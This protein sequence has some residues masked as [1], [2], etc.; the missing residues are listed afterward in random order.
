[1]LRAA[2]VFRATQP[3]RLAAS[4]RVAFHSSRTYLNEKVAAQSARVLENS[5]PVK[6]SN[7]FKRLLVSSLLFSTIAYGA[8]IFYSIKNDSFYEVFVEYIPFAERIIHFIED[9]R[10]KGKFSNWES[11]RNAIT[12]SHVIP[13][14]LDGTIQV[15]RAGVD[16]KAIDPSKISVKKSVAP[17]PVVPKEPE[18]T[19]AP[20]PIEMAINLPIVHLPLGADPEVLKYAESL[21]LLIQSINNHKSSAEAVERVSA[22]IL[23]LMSTAT[24]SQE[25]LKEKLEAEFKKKLE[26]VKSRHEREIQSQKDNYEFELQREQRALIENYNKRLAVELELTKNTTAAYVENQIRAIISESQRQFAGVVTEKVQDQRNARLAMIKKFSETVKELEQLTIQSNEIIAQAQK[27]AKLY[28]AL[29]GLFNALK[30]PEPVALESYITAISESA[31]EDTLLKV[32]LAAIPESVK[33]Q[34]VISPAQLADRFKVLEQEIRKAS[35][36][37]PN[38]GVAGHLG[39]VIFS[40][41][42]WKKSGAPVGN[43]IE[44]IIARTETALEQGNV[45]EA[46]A[47]INALNGWPKVLA[48]DWLA[49]G[50]QRT[51]LEFLVSLLSDEAKLWGIKL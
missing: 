35:L 20:A 29:N 14:K 33:K 46:V 28:L 43:D 22:S 26:A 24:T 27:T 45:H 39:S 48:A 12:S 42:L 10:F 51:E 37:P 15:P 47:E 41:L 44:S 34:G 30:S 17:T 4:G 8:G 13:D 31:G 21:N 49:E 9:Q 3:A 7:K 2:P 19:P 1:M 16:S 50:R 38:A 25:K 18:V 6:S 32:T 11:A 5:S 36:V 23:N 40:K